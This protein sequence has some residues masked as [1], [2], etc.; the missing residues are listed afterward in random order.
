MAWVTELMAYLGS[1][2]LGYKGCGLDYRACVLVVDWV[3]TV[4]DWGY[5][6][7]VM[8][9]VWPGLQMLQRS[10]TSCKS[11]VNSSSSVVTYL[12]SVLKVAGHLGFQHLEYHQA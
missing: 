12:D 5:G 1:H 11:S 6:A 10:F 4:L 2:G 3:M 9:K 7:W 8:M